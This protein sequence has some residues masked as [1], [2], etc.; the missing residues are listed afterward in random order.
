MPLIHIANPDDPRL[1]AYRNLNRTNLTRASGRFIAESRLLVER[2]LA[3][4]LQTE[5]I[6]ASARF[7]DELA[8]MVSESTLVYLVP[9]EQISQIIG[10]QFHRGM[11]A[12]GLRPANPSLAHVVAQAA[13]EQALL[14]VCPEVVDPT[15][16][17][18]IIRNCSAFGTSGLILGTHCADAYS[19]RV[20]RVSMGTLFT[21]PV[22]VSED[23]EADLDHLSRTYG[24]VRV[25]TVLH[26][27][28][29]PL[30]QAR[31]PRRLALL[32]G[33]EGHG[34]EPRWLAQSDLQVTLPM[35][36]NT[37]SLNV[38]TAT[39]VFLYHFTSMSANS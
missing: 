30:S 7:Q 22:R 5:S 37:D 19:R 4:T 12:C 39:G 20:A 24:F 16:L 9:H 26:Q 15:N 38:A 11:L 25:A 14:V 2:L 35:Q 18:G 8:T 32:F 31:R 13:A 28:A 23:L 6:L 21:L 1:D 29:L 34:L 27:T 36:R 3:S 33:T 10:F 17:G